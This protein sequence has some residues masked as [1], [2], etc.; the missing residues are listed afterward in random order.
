MSC[1]NLCKTDGGLLALPVKIVGFGGVTLNVTCFFYFCDT[2]VLLFLK[3]R[4][5]FSSS[6][7]VSQFQQY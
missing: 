6:F 7:Q 5:V 1:A 3:T 4:S 2:R